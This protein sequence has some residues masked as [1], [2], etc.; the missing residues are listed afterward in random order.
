MNSKFLCILLIVLFFAACINEQESAEYILR[1]YIEKKQDQF[2]HQEK[3]EALLFWEATLS[4]SRSDYAK[5][6]DLAV[7][8]QKDGEVED[9]SFQIDKF[10]KLD[11][12]VLSEKKDL[13]FLV[14]MKKSDMITDSILARQLDII[15]LKILSGEFDQDKYKKLLELKMDI[16]HYVQNYEL[17]IDGKV[18]SDYEIDSIRKNSSSPEF[19][20]KVFEAKRKL[21]KDMYPCCIELIK[22]RNDFA[23]DCGFENYYDF[24]LAA[25]EINRQDVENIIL[26]LDTTTIE[27]F[28]KAKRIIDKFVSKRFNIEK[29]QIKP[30]H[31]T[32]ERFIYFPV[33][34]SK[35]LDD[36]FVGKDVVKISASFYKECGLD[37]QD[38]LNESIINSD[39][40]DSKINFF[41][42]VDPYKDMRI[43]A[44]VNNNLQG[45]KVMMFLC[46]QAA[47]FKHV[48]CDLPYL[49]VYPNPIISEGVGDFFTNDIVHYGWLKEFVGVAPK[50]T[51]L[52]KIVCKHAYQI[53]KITKSRK[54]LTM[55]VF[56]KTLYENPDQNL[57]KLWWELNSK[58]LGYNK[59]DSILACDWA[60]NDYFL[61]MAGATQTELFAELFAAQ[62]SNKIK[63][64][65]EGLITDS[66]KVSKSE[67][68][69]D[70]MKKNI[71]QYGNVLPWNEL[72]EQA[73]D[74]KLT[75][76]Y[77][78]ESIVNLK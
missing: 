11:Q 72:I 57:G 62:L 19:F 21:V 63:T 42:N 16:L 64:S 3:K 78:F 24:L 51:A 33:K 9:Q 60:M 38:I 28:Q 67:F 23:R 49:L 22:M 44:N 5:L 48:S 53:E 2:R 77:Y 56:E 61:L 69:G 50:D 73:T 17:K 45:L 30:W 41:I 20:E 15:Y 75:A 32:N 74:E 46:S 10:K 6:A 55:A 1:N 12:K 59:P 47:T 68:V 65:Y 14:R 71:F 34:F 8:F 29:E 39:E 43:L 18:Y 35:I 31:Y 66:L 58:Y 40:L 70:F 25:Y 37:V 27:G 52:M 13:D 76:K 7:D 54:M 4:G 36:L 26:E